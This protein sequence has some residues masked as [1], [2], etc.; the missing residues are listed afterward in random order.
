MSSRLFKNTD[1]TLHVSS[2][3]ARDGNYSSRLWR[4]E[5]TAV[6][7]FCIIVLKRTCL[8]THD[9]SNGKEVVQKTVPQTCVDDNE[10]FKVF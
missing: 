3:Y 2:Y 1:T 9:R 7:V 10:H 5:S 6:N 4:F 8:I